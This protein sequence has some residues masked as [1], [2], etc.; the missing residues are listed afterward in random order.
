MS[1]GGAFTVLTVP[2]DQAWPYHG[3]PRMIFDAGT[4]D[5]NVPTIEVRV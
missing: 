4:F 1:A 3:R 2:V 5:M